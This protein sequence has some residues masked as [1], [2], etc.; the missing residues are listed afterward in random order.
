M[1]KRIEDGVTVEEG[2]RTQIFL[3][4]SSKI[5]GESGG[6]WEGTAVT[7]PCPNLQ[8]E[9]PYQ[10]QPLSPAV[11]HAMP[12]QLPWYRVYQRPHS[13]SL[14]LLGTGTLPEVGRQGGR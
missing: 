1:K 14:C 12:E 5:T 2:A 10:L 8:L 9:I 11:P 4:S 3:A 6:N 13:V 7:T